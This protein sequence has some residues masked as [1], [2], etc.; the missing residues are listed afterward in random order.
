MLRCRPS[1]KGKPTDPKLREK[2]TEEVKNET[3][4]DGGGKGQMA[5]WKGIRH[6]CTTI[7]SLI[8]ADI[9]PLKLP[10]SQRS[11]R[12]KEAATRMSL[13]ARMSQRKALPRRNRLRRRRPRRKSQRPTSH[14]PTTRTRKRRRPARMTK[15]M[16]TIRKMRL[17]AR[18][19]PKPTPEPKRAA[20]IAPL[21]PRV[22]R[23]RKT[24]RPRAR[25]RR[26]QRA[27]GSRLASLL[28]LAR[29]RRTLTTMRMARRRIRRR[30]RSLLN[31]DGWMLRTWAS[32]D[33]A[34]A[35]ATP[36]YLAR[37]SARCKDC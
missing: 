6:V 29:E 37:M 25:R 7:T 19:S 31:R 30:R 26:R 28:I 14:L 36:G 9:L 10:K 13:V 35:R 32:L 16:K 20:R 23:R 34:S 8:A 5:A 2:V 24:L 15:P 11:T 18:K 27:R 4:K 3:N 21:P 12:R 17:R 33:L 1:S 22:V